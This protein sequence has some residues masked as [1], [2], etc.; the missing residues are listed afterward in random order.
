MTTFV[1]A[2]YFYTFYAFGTQSWRNAGRYSPSAEQNTTERDLTDTACGPVIAYSL[3]E[4][5]LII[6]MKRAYGADVTVPPTLMNHLRTPTTMELPKLAI[7]R[8]TPAG[9]LRG[10]KK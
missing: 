4:N 7:E 1:I 2:R 3:V 5:L 9:V 10:C 6:T 8:A